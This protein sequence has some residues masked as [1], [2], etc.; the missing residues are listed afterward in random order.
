MKISS[1][2]FAFFLFSS[3]F[4]HA[5]TIGENFDFLNAEGEFLEIDLKITELS[6]EGLKKTKDSY[7]RPQFQKYVGKTIE[8]VSLHEIETTLQ[9]E[10]IFDKIDVQLSKIDD[11]NARLSINVT[12]KITFIPLPFA[13]YSSSGFMGGLMVMDTNAFGVKDTV[14]LGAIGSPT[15]ITGIAIFSK[16]PKNDGSLGYSISGSF[17]KNSQEILNLE[18]ETALEYKNISG[19]ASFSVSRKL[20]SWQTVRAGFSF[21]GNHADEDEKY[22]TSL[23][24]SAFLGTFSL[25]Y[26]ASNVNWNGW[27]LSTAA[28]AA[29][30]EAT[31]RFHTENDD[32]PFWGKAL[33]ASASIQKPFLLE[34]FR[35]TARVAGAYS[36]DRPIS[37][38]DGGSSV[39]VTILPGKFKTQRI[40]GAQAGGEFAIFKFGFGLF[41]VYADYQ[42]SISD[43]F[44]IKNDAE[45]AVVCHGPDFGARLYL[46]KIAF[47]ALAFGM[48]RNIP[49]EYWQFSFSAG[50]SF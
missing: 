27:F 40:A 49:K 32:V 36:K 44:S 13:A 8:E 43:D 37:M 23:L 42:V 15:S 35:L 1:C 12:E 2:V 22:P 25:N 34:R 30:A 46:S 7:I 48:S 21:A 18:E 5:Q 4:L 45:N 20:S 31:T 33:K 28:F 39:G 14:V 3:A 50:I 24:E 9:A 17:S 38:W 19:S 6:I 29:S 26:N 41:S 47:P 16:P 10:G 11:Q